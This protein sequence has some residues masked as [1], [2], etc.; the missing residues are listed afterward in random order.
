MAAARSLNYSSILE[1]RGK[2]SPAV[3][4][5]GAAAAFQSSSTYVHRH[6]DAFK[7]K[8]PVDEPVLTLINICFV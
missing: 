6:G 3:T 2:E 7:T 8:N 1:Q 5:G 4:S